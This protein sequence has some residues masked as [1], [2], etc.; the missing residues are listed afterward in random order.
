MNIEEHSELMRKIWITRKCRIEASERLLKKHN[1]Y[2][3]I[4]V[5]YSIMLVVYSIW[6]IQSFNLSGQITEASLFIL[7]VSIVFSLFSLFVS[8]KNLQGK[9][10]NLKINYLELDKIWGI[11]K[12]VDPKDAQAISGIRDQYNNLLAAVDN[13]EEI[14]YYRVILSVTEER[15]NLDEKTQFEYEKFIK[16]Y[17]RRKWWLKNCLYTVPILSP[18]AMK[19]FLMLLNYIFPAL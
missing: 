15:N 4:L 8:S 7:V 17:D 12:R 13:H 19:F 14:D 18:L 10:F 11:L 2:Q 3:A 9:Y 5:Y 1:L 16:N 6:N